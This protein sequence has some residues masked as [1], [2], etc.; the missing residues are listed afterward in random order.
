M[1][2]GGLLD[3]VDSTGVDSA[4]ISAGANWKASG[5]EDGDIIPADENEKGAGAGNV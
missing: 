3:G 1:K 5:G 2:A 4:T